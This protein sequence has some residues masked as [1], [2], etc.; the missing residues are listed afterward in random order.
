MGREKAKKV[1]AKVK[2]RHFPSVRPSRSANCNWR[3]WPLDPG[4][5]R[6]PPYLA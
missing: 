5:S 1:E 2:R 6:R 3:D 4:K